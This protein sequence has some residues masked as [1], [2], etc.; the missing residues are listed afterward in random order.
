M[1]GMVTS[2]EYFISINGQLY[3]VTW[4]RLAVIAGA[5]LVVISIVVA[6]LPRRP[7]A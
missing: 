4:A 5:I 2:S 6:F 7:K 3:Q 1:L